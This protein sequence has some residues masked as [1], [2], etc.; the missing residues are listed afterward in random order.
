MKEM[1]LGIVGCGDIARYM[2]FFAWANRRIRLAAACD[3]T[4]EKAEALSRRYRIRQVYTDYEEMLSQTALEAVYLAVPHDLH[5][6]MIE[7]AVSTG[8]AVFVEKPITRTLEEGV[9]VAQ[10]STEKG[11]KIGVNYQYRYDSGCYALA[12]AAQSG[13]LGR[14]L[15]GR[16]NLPWHRQ[17]SYFETSGWHA[18][19]E[20]SGGGTLL[21][22]GSHLL[23]I[24]LWA[25]GGKPQTASGF[26]DQRV[27]TD[28]EVEDLAMGTIEMEDG[29]CIQICSSMVAVPEQALSLEIYG[30][31]GTA[32]YRNL[33]RP[34]VIFR[35]VKVQKEKPPARGLHALQRSLEGFRAWVME[36]KPYL[37][38][39]E[40]ALPAL[41]AV[42]AIYRSARSG[43]KE[44]IK[45]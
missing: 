3:V 9:R 34:Q 43:R 12:R 11:I 7:A 13:G 35:G 5:A 15:Y 14:I 25:S 2:A 45:W 4:R 38:P 44:P 27:Y 24:L 21:T 28:V 36:G 33:P 6:G 10:L 29:A 19:Q 20:Q 39:A 40:A 41:A 16:A 22:Q 1:R 32:V 23:D 8:I 42:N 18:S 17:K 30:E 31:Q 37:S 26:T